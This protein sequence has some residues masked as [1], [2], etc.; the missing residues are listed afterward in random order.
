MREWL[1][2]AVR[3]FHVFAG[4]MWVGQTY[5]FTWLDGQFG[6]LEAQKAAG[7]EQAPALW[8]VHSGGFYTV[9]KQKSLGVGPEQVHW[10]R[11]EAAMTWLSGMVLLFL[12]YYFG[13]GLIDTDVADI[14]L[15]KGIAIGLGAL[16]LGWLIYDRRGA[17]VAGEVMP[18][19]FAIF[20]LI[21]IAA[22][23]WGL[24][25]VFSG[26]AAYIHVG[27]IF[28]TIM[29]LNVWM[30]ILPAQ[31]KMIA[32]AAA[33]DSVRSVTRS[34]SQ[35]AFQTQHLH[36]GSSCL[37]HDQQSF[38]CRDLREHLRLGNS[39][40]SGRRRMG[41]RG[42]RSAV[43]R[44]PDSAQWANTK[45]RAEEVIARCRKLATFSEDAGSTRRT[46]LSRADARLP[47]RNH[48]MDGA[49]GSAGKNRCSRK[50]GGRSILASTVEAP[51]LLIGSHLDTVPNAGAYDGILGVVLAIALLEDL[52]WTPASFRNRSCG[53]FRRRRSSLR[54]PV[55]RQPRAWSGRLD[56]ELLNRVDA[57]GIS[58]RKAI[59][60]FGLNPAEIPQAAMKDDVLGYVEFHIEQGP[61][62]EKL[63][64][65]L[66]S[67]RG[68]CRTKPTWNSHL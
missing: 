14:S 67:G 17:I 58:V 24:T 39:G 44:S 10:F 50:L 28:G 38:S 53:L 52:R 45:K 65:P 63:G 19:R 55:H 27:A 29:T 68:D 35:I 32:A 42:A 43:P 48:A 49:A 62:L 4:I 30:R 12:L 36:G 9:E 61:V 41:C 16:V 46:F 66:G 13:G 59:E 23:A 34:A 15:A 18:P 3:W 37:H 64:L 1:Q 5:Y 21:V 56:E 6:K 47:S 57:R 8:M 7:D 31:R 40:R 11:W 2:L 51:R 33:G 20:S 22:M 26:R 60:D 54:R 25:H